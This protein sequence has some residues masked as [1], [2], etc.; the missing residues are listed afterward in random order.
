MQSHYLNQCKLKQHEQIKGLFLHSNTNTS[1]SFRIQFVKYKFYSKNLTS[2]SSKKIRNVLN[3]E[4]NQRG[5]NS[6]TPSVWNPDVMMDR[7]CIRQTGYR[8]WELGDRSI[9]KS[10]L[11]SKGRVMTDDMY[12]QTSNISRELVFSQSAS[13]DRVVRRWFDVFFDVGFHKL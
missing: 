4:T 1:F 5:I 2:I 9:W 12:R 11:C 3:R 6:P 13:V 8:K 10:F 7:I